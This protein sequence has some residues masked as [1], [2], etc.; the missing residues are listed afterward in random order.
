MKREIIYF[1]EVG[2]K[3]ASKALDEVIET[4]NKHSQEL[5]ANGY[6][7]TIDDIKLIAEQNKK[8]K[9]EVY[10]NELKNICSYFGV[11]Y[12]KVCTFEYRITNNMFS[13][14]AVGKCK[15]LYNF[16]NDLSKSF[17][18]HSYLADSKYI[19]IIDN[20]ASKS[21]DADELLKEENSFYTENDR[22]NEILAL[23]KKLQELYKEYQKLNVRSRDIAHIINNTT[24]DINPQV[25]KQL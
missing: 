20:V 1:N 25:F 14:M 16:S 12:N 23:T 15:Y 4:I 21:I 6:K 22:Q 17:T 9:T 11:D 3:Q 5:T 18:L 24:L 8:F 10:K 13:E 19:D 2:F 7:L